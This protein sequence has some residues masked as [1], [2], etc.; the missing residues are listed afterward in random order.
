M[1]N[2]CS[3]TPFNMYWCHPAATRF[4]GELL[5]GAIEKLRTANPQITQG[6]IDLIHTY[7]ITFKEINV[8]KILMYPHPRMDPYKW[9]LSCSVQQDHPNHVTLFCKL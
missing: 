5:S 1:Y 7:A 2:F 6:T 9:N 8:I 4:P 3:V